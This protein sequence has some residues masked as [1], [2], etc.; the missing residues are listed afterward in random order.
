MATTV[1]TLHESKTTIDRQH[2]PGHVCS[3][4]RQQKGDERGYLVSFSQSL[5]RIGA[6]SRL[7]ACFIER[8][9]WDPILAR[10]ARHDRI[11]GWA[12]TCKLDRKTPHQQLVRGLRLHRRRKGH[13][14]CEPMGHET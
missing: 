2:G 11:G 3:V 6:G 4:L 1:A 5:Q 10:I 8:P 14:G 12:W 7:P 9:E 13:I